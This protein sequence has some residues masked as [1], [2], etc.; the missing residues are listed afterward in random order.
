MTLNNELTQA[1]SGRVLII[2]NHMDGLGI[3]L[4]QLI[5]TLNLIKDQQQHG[6]NQTITVF[7]DLLEVGKELAKMPNG[8]VAKINEIANERNWSSD[9]KIANVYF[10]LKYTDQQPGFGHTFGSIVK[11]SQQKPVISSTSSNDALQKPQYSERTRVDNIKDNIENR[12]KRRDIIFGLY[13]TNQRASQWYRDDVVCHL[14]ELPKGNANTTFGK[15]NAEKEIAKNASEFFTKLNSNHQ[16]Y[17]GELDKHFTPIP[18]YDA[19]HTGGRREHGPDHG[20]AV[21]EL[22]PYIID[23]YKSPS[24][25]GLFS[26]LNFKEIQKEKN[27]GIIEIATGLHDIARTTHGVDTDEYINSPLTYITLRRA[28]CSHAEATLYTY[29]A[30][31]KNSTKCR[32]YNNGIK[33]LLDSLDLEEKT[34]GTKGGV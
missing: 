28:G 15:C 18:N 9:I 4:N 14:L 32:D 27:L 7:T 22:V 17:I 20:R 33:N 3:T 11:N 13:E 24:K 10:L 26:D 6:F 30:A 23:G 5:E 31:N 21:M 1:T 8:R 34:F 12:T 29:A 2:Q 19:Y 16:Q 25:I